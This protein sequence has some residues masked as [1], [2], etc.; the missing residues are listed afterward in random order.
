M[1]IIFADIGKLM[2][3]FVQKLKFLNGYEFDK[4]IYNIDKI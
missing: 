2:I 4:F 3:I 1:H